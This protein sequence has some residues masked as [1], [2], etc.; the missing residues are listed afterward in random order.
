MSGL[1]A[2]SLTVM[3]EDPEIIDYMANRNVSGSVGVRDIDEESQD[4][5]FSTSTLWWND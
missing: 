3:R 1:L 4:I 5:I 2:K